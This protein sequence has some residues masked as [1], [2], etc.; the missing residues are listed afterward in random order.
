MPTPPPP[1]T[2]LTDDSEN[3]AVSWWRGG[4]RGHGEHYGARGGRGNTLLWEEK[5]RGEETWAR[6]PR[7]EPGCP[8][9]ATSEPESRRCREECPRTRLRNS[10]FTTTPPRDRV[11]ASCDYRLRHPALSLRCSPHLESTVLRRLHFEN[12]LSAKVL[13]APNFQKKNIFS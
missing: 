5:R 1:T 9:H 8:G 3:V 11:R 13:G 12:G 4:A 6:D 7:R 2:Q 10:S